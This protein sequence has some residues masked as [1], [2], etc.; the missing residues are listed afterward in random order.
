MFIRGSSFRL[1]IDEYLAVAHERRLHHAR[2]ERLV[3][4][5]DVDGV[6]DRDTHGQACERYRLADRGREGAAGDLALA[7]RGANFLVGAQHAAGIGEQEP[8]EL[9][10]LPAALELLSAG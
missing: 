9:A 3:A 8:Q 1:G 10:L 6:S 2:A 7:L 4:D 5:E